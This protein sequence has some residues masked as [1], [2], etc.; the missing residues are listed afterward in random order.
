[1]A[2]LMRLNV[3]SCQVIESFISETLLRQTF[4][5]DYRRPQQKITEFTKIC[6]IQKKILPL[7][8]RKARIV[9]HKLRK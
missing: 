8:Q 6:H 7:P 9:G 2:V 3:F 5:V 1:M 4:A